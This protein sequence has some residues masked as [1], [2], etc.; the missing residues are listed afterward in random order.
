LELEVEIEAIVDA[1]E[2][3]I[4]LGIPPIPI[5]YQH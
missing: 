3:L 4:P 2:L 1:L 5:Y